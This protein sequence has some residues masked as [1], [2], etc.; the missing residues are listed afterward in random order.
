MSAPP[1]A[2]P[3]ASRVE[4]AIDGMTCAT[5]RGCGGGRR[6]RPAARRTRDRDG[7][8]GPAH[9]PAHRRPRTVAALPP[10]AL[11]LLNPTIAGAAMAF[12]SVFVV[13]NGLRLRRFTP[14]AA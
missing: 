5:G 12:S 9:G 4:P 6:A 14:R 3:D 2:A 7:R 1:A 11:G 8:A 13:A 10:A